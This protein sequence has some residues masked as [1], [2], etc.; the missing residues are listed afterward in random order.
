MLN[1]KTSTGPIGVNVISVPLSAQW[2][3]LSLWMRR[4]WVEECIFNVSGRVLQNLSGVIASHS[5]EV[6]QSQTDVSAR[7]VQR[8]AHPDNAHDQLRHPCIHPNRLSFFRGMDCIYVRAVKIVLTLF[9]TWAPA[10]IGATIA[11]TLKMC[12]ARGSWC[13]EMI[14][15]RPRAE[16]LPQSF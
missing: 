7:L 6:P 2:L 12:R 8:S 3:P 5:Q 11:H 15:Q 10:L 14:Y 9:I 1:S 16:L 13:K 4:W